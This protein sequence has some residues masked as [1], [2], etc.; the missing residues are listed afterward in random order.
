L[1]AAR[2]QR[3]V[4]V[5]ERLGIHVVGDPASL[6]L[7]EQPPVSQSDLAPDRISVEAAAQ[8]V[9]GV[10]ASALERQQEARRRTPRP[11][12]AAAPTLADAG[13]RALARELWKRQTDRWRGRR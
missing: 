1:V 3:R 12:P 9:T 8:A 5:I 4:E 10:V 2:S 6:L 11:A 7:P 13:R